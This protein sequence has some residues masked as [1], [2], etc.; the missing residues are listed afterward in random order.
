VDPPELQRA[1]AWG[2]TDLIDYGP[3][4]TAASKPICTINRLGPDTLSLVSR[5][6]CGLSAVP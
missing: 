2:W 4:V 1:E 6:A 5:V 3:Q